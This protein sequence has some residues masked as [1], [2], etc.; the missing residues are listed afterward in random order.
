M[1]KLLNKFDAQKK[2]DYDE[3]SKISLVQNVIIL[4]IP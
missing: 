2:F 1:S 3:K 4:F